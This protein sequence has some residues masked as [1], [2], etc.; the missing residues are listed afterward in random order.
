MLDPRNLIRDCYKA[1]LNLHEMTENEVEMELVIVQEKLEELR[2]K[3]LA[4]S[5]DHLKACLK[6]AQDKGNE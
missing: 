4:M 2:A 5:Q 6:L 3:V 1:G